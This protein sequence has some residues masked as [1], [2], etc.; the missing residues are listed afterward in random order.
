MSDK[1]NIAEDAPTNCMGAS[2]STSGPI[3][4]YDPLLMKKKKKSGLVPLS[5]FSRLKPGEKKT[6]E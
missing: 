3:S 2:S 5:V 1:K 4:S 6:S